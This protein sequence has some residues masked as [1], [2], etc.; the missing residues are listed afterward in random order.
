VTRRTIRWRWRPGT[1]PRRPPPQPFFLAQ[2]QPNPFN[3]TTTIRFGLP[4]TGP[5][6]LTLFNA[7]GQQ[8]VV[9]LDGTCAA[10][11]HVVRLD[12]T[13]LASGGLSLSPAERRRDE[14]RK[15]LV[16]R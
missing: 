16:L 7:L 13:D 5:V 12:A 10:G 9:L 3:P 4:E 1:R 11:E 15:M 8:V 2:N 6:R 14:W